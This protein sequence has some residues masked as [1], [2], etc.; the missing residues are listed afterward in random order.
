MSKR[1]LKADDESGFI[2][3]W[4]DEIADLASNE[5]VRIVVTLRAPVQAEGLV[6]HCEAFKWDWLDSDVLYA[7]FSQPYPSHTATRLHAALY[8]ALVRLGVEIRD[9]RRVEAGEESP[10]PID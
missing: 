9:R 3:A 5:D 4:K 10:G 7:S 2:R 1:Q 8:R 6:I